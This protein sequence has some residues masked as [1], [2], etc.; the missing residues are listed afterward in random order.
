[1]MD[2]KLGMR[3]VVV[4]ER[5]PETRSSGKRNSIATTP[6]KGRRRIRRIVDSDEESEMDFPKNPICW[7]P[8]ENLTEGGSDCPNASV[9]EQ[10]ERPVFVSRRVKTETTTIISISAASKFI[11]EKFTNKSEGTMLP[12]QTTS[13]QNNS[14]NSTFTQTRNFVSL[15]NCDDDIII[16]SSDDESVFV[17]NSTENSLED[18]D[19]LSDRLPVEEETEESSNKKSLEEDKNEMESLKKKSK[20]ETNAEEIARLKSLVESGRFSQKGKTTLP[21]EAKA[22]Y[23]SEKKRL[24]YSVSLLATSNDTTSSCTKFRRGKGKSNTSRSV[25]AKMCKQQDLEGYVRSLKE[26]PKNSSTV[27][28]STKVVEP[29]SVMGKMSKSLTIRSPSPI[30]RTCTQN[31]RQV[32]VKVCYFHS[33]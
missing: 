6:V 9:V 31:F 20:L 4:L 3:C 27:Q 23:P 30:P 12:L 18:C 28:P 1:M 8:R 26:A 5:L 33:L 22:L 15:Q 25:R 17:E 13:S 29:T 7:I 32:L 10:T 19:P 14:E 2:P 21:T 11:V 24:N 16:L